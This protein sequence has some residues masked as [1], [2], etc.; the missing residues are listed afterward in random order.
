MLKELNKFNLDKFSE[1]LESGEADDDLVL[2]IIE[3]TLTRPDIVQI[4]NN[5]VRKQRDEFIENLLSLT[6]S[7]SNKV[8]SLIISK[9]KIIKVSEELFDKISAFIKQCDISNEPKEIQVWSH[10]KRVESEFELIHKDLK[11]YLSKRSKPKNKVLSPYSIIENDKGSSFSADAASEHLVQYLSITLQLLSYEFKMFDSGKVVIPDQASVNDTNVFQAGSIE[12]LA[13]SWREVEDSCQRSILFGGDVFRCRE[14]E[15]QKEARENGV[16]L[17]YHYERNES[18]YEMFD[19]ISIERVK[20]RSL[21]HYLDILSNPE[22]RK[23]VASN[24]DTV[25]NLNERSFLSEDE[26]LTCILLGDIFC[27]NIL[28]DEREYNG[29]TLAEWIR[30]YSTLQRISK[31]IESGKNR[32]ILSHE[33]IV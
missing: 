6:S 21:Q 5:K 19:A 9:A 11:S 20:K 26:I 29:L 3:S 30:S 15:V 2:K 8:K 7:Y 23:K 32:N 22:L 13:R 14:S 1:Y 31:E 4:R 18:D 16:K 24:I 25:G 17:S 33:Y 12:L 27:V 10:L 28:E